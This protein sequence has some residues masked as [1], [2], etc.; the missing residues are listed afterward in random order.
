M[1][2]YS[3]VFGSQ[4]PEK[5]MEL[6]K[7]KDIGEAP[8]AVQNLARQYYEH[9]EAKDY[10]SASILLNNNWN[11][12]RQYYFGT[13]MLNKL[14]EELYNAQLFALNNN[15]V[16]ISSTEPDVSESINS[17]PWLRPLD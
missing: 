12:L 6:T 17:T 9:M 1:A 10:A 13:Q 2:N 5:E 16:I 15:T 14:E 4:F 7:Y 3:R 8:S 11:G